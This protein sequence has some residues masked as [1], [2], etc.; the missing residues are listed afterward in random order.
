[1]A[2]A[3]AAAWLHQA[4]HHRLPGSPPRKAGAGPRAGGAGDAAKAV[5][6]SVASSVSI[7]VC[8]KYLMSVLGFRHATTLTAAH[9]FCTAFALRL[10]RALGWL[11]RRDLARA[12]VLAFGVMHGLSIASLNLS[13]AL[14]SVGF[15]QMGKLGI[16]PLTVL[17]E[18]VAHRKVFSP[19]V[20]GSLGVL[21]GG[22]GYATVHD[23]QVNAAGCAV[24]LVSAVVTALQQVRTGE[25]QK[26]LDVS[27]SQLLLHSSPTM[28]CFLLVT[29]PF[30]DYGVTGTSLL[31]FPYTRQV[32]GCIALSCLIAIGVNMGTFAVIGKLDAVTYQVIGHF[33]TIIILFFGFYFLGNKS[34]PRNVLGIAV[35]MVG[36]V[37]YS[38]EKHKLSRRPKEKGDGALHR[39]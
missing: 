35:A 23:V 31:A 1:M 21:L 19:G 18:K 26:R 2:P 32:V 25:I 7:V 11:E 37:G 24:A 34:T 29:G 15:Y 10:A 17:I 3:P 39:V 6:L 9:G 5:V 38:Y 16:I 13:L 8:N 22:I 36:V 4:H 28:G 33:K 20:V 12:D 14:N 27:S 30:I